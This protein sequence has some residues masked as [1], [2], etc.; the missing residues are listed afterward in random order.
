METTYWTR[1]KQKVCNAIIRTLSDTEHGNVSDHSH[2]PDSAHDSV[3]KDLGKSEFYIIYFFK[4][5]TL[6]NAHIIGI[7]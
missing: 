5:F 3:L 4:F 6:S 7:K 1:E 2:A